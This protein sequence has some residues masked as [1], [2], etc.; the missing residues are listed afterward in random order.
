MRILMRAL[1][2]IIERLRFPSAPSFYAFAD[3]FIIIFSDSE[4][5][6]NNNIY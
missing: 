6:K 4:D 2:F 5:L 3:T 1:S